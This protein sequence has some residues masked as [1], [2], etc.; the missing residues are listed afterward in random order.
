M[1]KI[2][3]KLQCPIDKVFGHKYTG[4]SIKAPFISF[5][6]A[7]TIFTAPNGAVFCYHYFRKTGAD[8][9]RYCPPPEPA[10]ESLATSGFFGVK[11]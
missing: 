11:C 2:I 6:F 3:A 8:G 7:P 1:S 9:K 10:P 4:F 5:S